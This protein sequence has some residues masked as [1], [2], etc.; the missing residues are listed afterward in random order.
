MSCMHI[1]DGQDVDCS[2]GPIKM[3]SVLVE[4]PLTVFLEVNLYSM[5]E[6]MVCCVN[7]T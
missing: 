3:L 5:A 1:G 7:L 2:S 4:V 6:K